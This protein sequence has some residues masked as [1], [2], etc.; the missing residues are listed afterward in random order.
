LDLYLSRG[1]KDLQKKHEF[2]KNNYKLAKPRT[3]P[4]DNKQYFK[5][6]KLISR[7][8][9]KL[10]PMHLLNNKLRPKPMHLLNKKHNKLLL[11]KVPKKQAEYLERVKNMFK[12]SLV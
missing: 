6:N 5:L 1:K 12:S 10:K 4:Q 2:D 11:Q 7:V 9:N 8:N 3:R